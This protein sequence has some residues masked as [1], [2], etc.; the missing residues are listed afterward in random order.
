MYRTYIISHFDIF[1]KGFLKKISK[2]HRFFAVLKIK[3]V[4]Y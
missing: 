4:S 2:K 1:V 3:A